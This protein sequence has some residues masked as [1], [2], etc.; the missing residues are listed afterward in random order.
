MYLGASQVVATIEVVPKAK[1]Y[2][3]VKSQETVKSQ[4]RAHLC[5]CMASCISAITDPKMTPARCHSIF[6]GV[7][8][9]LRNVS[10]IATA[11]GEPV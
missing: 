11:L 5:R 3:F 4:R 2:R 9:H 8:V 6:A 1:L 10:G 7:P